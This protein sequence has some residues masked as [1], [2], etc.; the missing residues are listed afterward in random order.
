MQ[1]QVPQYIDIEDKL[2][3]PLSFK[4]FAFLA[5]GAGFSFILYRFIPWFYVAAPLMVLTVGASVAL[6]FFNINRR[7]VLT[8]LEYATYYALRPKLYVWRHIDKKQKEA[9][10]TQDQQDADLGLVPQLSESKLKDLSW[11]LDVRAIQH[12][13]LLPNENARAATPNL[14]IPPQE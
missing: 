13:S 2:F 4:Q 10:K 1:F 12:E 6:A 3:G 11:S 9:K 8:M 7:P 5:G 14:V